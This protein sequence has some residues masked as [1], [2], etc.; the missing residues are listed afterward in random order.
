MT[1]RDFPLPPSYPDM[2]TMMMTARELR[3]TLEDIWAWVDK[4]EMAHESIAPSQQV[5]QEMRGL[6]RLLINE[7]L[8]RHADEPGR[9]AE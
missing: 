4:A 7:R 2:D 5:V 3:E 8:E 6:M 9:S 1:S